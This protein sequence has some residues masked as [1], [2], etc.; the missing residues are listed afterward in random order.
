M[1]EGG[2]LTIETRFEPNSKAAI[3]KAGDSVL[4]VSDDGVGMDAETMGKVFEPFFTTKHRGTGL[5]L[6]TAR[7]VLERHHG[8]I[9]LESPSGG[10]TVVIVTLP[11]N[12]KHAA[13]PSAENPA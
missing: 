3:S 13:A 2:T 9:A 1:P 10:G 11:L 7:R 12:P 8:S 4:V 5:G 6:P